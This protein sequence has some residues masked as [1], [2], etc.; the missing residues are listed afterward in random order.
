[1]FNFSVYF[2]EEIMQKIVK[3]CT[4]VL[5]FYIFFY[6]LGH[7]RELP[8]FMRELKLLALLHRYNL[9]F[10]KLDQFYSSGITS[11]VQTFNLCSRL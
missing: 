1:M 2:P 4:H 6:I 10:L 3:L 9:V 7:C 5:Q 11:F 8:F